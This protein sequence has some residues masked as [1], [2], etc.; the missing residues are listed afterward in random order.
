[1]KAKVWLQRVTCECG[2]PMHG[3]GM[4]GAG[5]ARTIRCSQSGCEN[6]EKEFEM[7]TM[8]IELREVEE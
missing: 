3:A 8:E 7:P 2:A 4:V 1:M 6:A 5:I